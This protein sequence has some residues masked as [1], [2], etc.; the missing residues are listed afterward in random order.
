MNQIELGGNKMV[1]LFFIALIIGI[2]QIIKES[3]DKNHPIP[4]SYWNNQD[5]MNQDR[6]RGVFE[7]DIISN[8]SAG[9]YNTPDKIYPAYQNPRH[10]IVD[11]ERYNR[12]IA[13]FGKDTVDKDVRRGF[14]SVKI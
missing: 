6:L 13:L 14:Y 4:L 7:K 12:D 9:R 11:I 2:V 10:R 5:L 1:S 3:Y 8:M